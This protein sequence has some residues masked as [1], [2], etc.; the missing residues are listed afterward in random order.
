M[1]V[2]AP[3]GDKI[4]DIK[5]MFYE[6]LEHVFDKFPKYP[7]KILLGDFKAKVGKTFS[8]QQLGMRVCMKLVMIMELRVVNFATSKNLTVK[9]TMFPHRNIHKF[10]WTSPD[11]KIHNQIDHILIDRRRHSSILDVRSFRA[12]DCDTDHYL[13]VAK[14]KERLAVSKQT[15]HRVHMERFNLKKLNEVE[16]KEQYRVEISNRFTALENLDTEVDVNKAWETIRE[17][18]KM[19]AKESLGYYEPKKHKPWFDEGCS[20][21]LDQRKQPKLQWL[22][23]PSELNGDNLNNI[24]RETSRHFRNKK[25]EYLKDKIDDLAMNSKNKNIRDL[26][27]GINDFK[28]GYQPSSNLVMDENGDLLADSHNILNMWKNYISKLLNVYRNKHPYLEWDGGDWS[29]SGFCYFAPPRNS[30]RSPLDRGLCGP[31][32][33]SGRCEEDKNLTLS[34]IEPG[35]FSP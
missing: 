23:D 7:M 2:H 22:Q 1:T 29:A 26:Y 20:K 21:L 34:G 30:R 28:R 27:R 25:R 11:G 17:N 18:I 15:T 35:Q 33:R 19:S 5:D 12:A 32:S 3:T 13:V 6:E 14:V 9:S 10:T 4:D 16:G 31:H 24:I 8:S